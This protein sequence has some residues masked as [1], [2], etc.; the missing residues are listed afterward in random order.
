M[1]VPGTPITQMRLGFEDDESSDTGTLTG[2]DVGGSTSADK[3]DGKSGTPSLE[4]LFQ[5]EDTSD[6]PIISWFGDVYMLDSTSI[7]VK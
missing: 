7:F 3:D 5:S 1:L 4:R 2:R 6:T